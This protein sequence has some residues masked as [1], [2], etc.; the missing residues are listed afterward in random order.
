M[1]PA[2]IAQ[3]DIA[4]T[5]RLK[6]L[7]AIQ[8]GSTM[9]YEVTYSNVGVGDYFNDGSIQLPLGL[10]FIMPPGS[11][12]GS[13]TD[14]DTNDNITIASCNTLGPSSNLGPGAA[15]YPG[16]VTG[17]NLN[18]SGVIAPGESFALNMTLTAGADFASGATG[19]WA[20]G[21][22]VEP[23]VILFQVMAQGGVN[24]FEKPSNNYTNLVYDSA[25]LQATVARC[26]GQGET[27]TDGTG[28]FRVSFNKDIPESEFDACDIDLD[29]KGS[30]S[31]ITQIG[32]N[33]WEVQVSGIAQGETLALILNADSIR[34]F[35]MLQMLFKF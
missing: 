11:T 14:I 35:F 8:S 12:L 1:S 32:D 19:E 33:L 28:C 13:I 26:P 23:D 10:Y 5:T 27:T 30:V 6:T 18:L 21:V 4:I 25:A 17:C 9:N 20:I 15:P 2:I 29:G 16:V 24:M 22:A 31:N 34:D 7:G 3:S